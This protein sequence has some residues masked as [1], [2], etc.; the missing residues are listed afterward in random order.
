MNFAGLENDQI[1]SGLTIRPEFG[2][3]DVLAVDLLVD[4]L[5]VVVPLERKINNCNRGQTN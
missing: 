3:I 5:L 1:L 2:A 4:R